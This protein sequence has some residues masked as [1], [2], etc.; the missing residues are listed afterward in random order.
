MDGQY[1]MIDGAR[2]KRMQDKRKNIVTLSRPKNDWHGNFMRRY[3]ATKRK[4]ELDVDMLILVLK[5]SVDGEAAP[6]QYDSTQ[7]PDLSLPALCQPDSVR[8]SGPDC[9]DVTTIHP[10]GNKTFIVSIDLQKIK[11]SGL[12][13][14]VLNHELGHVK[15]RKDMS[16]DIMSF[17]V[18]QNEKGQLFQ[19]SPYYKTN[20][21]YP[22]SAHWNGSGLTV[23]RWS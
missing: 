9:T 18:I 11:S 12:F 4:N 22:Y 13:Y 5:P 6:P 7:E 23:E 15:G 19:H 8:A 14:N 10:D 20:F 16:G 1:I 2:Y 17:T 3:R 21:R